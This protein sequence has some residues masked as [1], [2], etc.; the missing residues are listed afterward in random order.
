VRSMR[1]ISDLKVWGALMRLEMA[2]EADSNF[3][4]PSPRFVPADASSFGTHRVPSS[5]IIDGSDTLA[6]WCTTS[7]SRDIVSRP[8]S[9]H[10][11]RA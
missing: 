2:L 5:G 3:L 4:I 8:R 6:S 11:Q 7:E 10:V 9:Q 1:C